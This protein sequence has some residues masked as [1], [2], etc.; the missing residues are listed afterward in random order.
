MISCHGAVARNALM[1]EPMAAAS[2]NAGMMIDTAE[3]SAMSV[4]PPIFRV[5]NLKGPYAIEQI[6]EQLPVPGDDVGQQ[7]DD[8]HLETDDHHDG[9][10]NQRG[11]VLERLVVK[12]EVEKAQAAEESDGE[13]EEPEIGEHL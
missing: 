4:F 1:T 8:Q 7:A 10:R 5:R 2:L 11:E 3:G 6:L 12:I 13:D 9:R